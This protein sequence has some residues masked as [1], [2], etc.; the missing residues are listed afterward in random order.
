MTSYSIDGATM[1]CALCQR[2]LP[3]RDN[4]EEAR[5]GAGGEVYC[6]RLCAE[7]AQQPARRLIRRC[8]YCGGPLGLMIHRYYRMR[9]C[10]EAHMRAYCRRLAEETRAKIQRLAVS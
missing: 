7:R 9:F 3:A 6:S 5:R 2:M 1:R 10:C 4:Q 8:D